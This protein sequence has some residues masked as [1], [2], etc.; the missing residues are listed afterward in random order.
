VHHAFQQNV[1]VLLNHVKNEDFL[2]FSDVKLPLTIPLRSS[3]SDQQAILCVYTYY[4]ET[5]LLNPLK[6]LYAYVFLMHRELLDL[7]VILY[8]QT[9]DCKK[10]QQFLVEIGRAHVLTPVTFRSRMPSSA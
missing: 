9:F 5:S 7:S 2:L 10:H 8:F 4:K 3:K 6:L 1:Y